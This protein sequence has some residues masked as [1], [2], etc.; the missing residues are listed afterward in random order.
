MFALGACDVL[1]RYGRSRNMQRTLVRFPQFAWLVGS[2]TSAGALVSA[3]Q[4]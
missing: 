3:Q 2:E 1:S 4:F